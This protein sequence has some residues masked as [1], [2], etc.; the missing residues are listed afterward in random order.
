M[1]QRV[2]L[3]MLRQREQ[4]RRVMLPARMRGKCGWSDACILNMS[5]RGMLIY[6]KGIAEPGAFVEIRRGGQLVVGR[7]VW[8]EN[9]RI[10]LHSQD[11]VRI[12]DIINSAAAAVEGGQPGGEIAE[13]RYVPRKADNSL[14]YA[15]AMEFMFVVLL[16]ATLAAS[17]A[18]EVRDALGTPFTAV[19]AALGSD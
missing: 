4:R 2:G 6:S 18:Y 14:T 13:R 10:G 19:R 7:V 3:S 16:G 5:S 17:V 12:A 1:L 8:R 15:R 9:Q 11:P